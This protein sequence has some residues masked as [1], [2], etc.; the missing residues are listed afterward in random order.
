MEN[1]AIGVGVA[2]GLHLGFVDFL[3]PV[4]ELEKADLLK[5]PYEDR[6]VQFTFFF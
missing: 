3:W 6:I 2:A 1:R 4:F 5:K